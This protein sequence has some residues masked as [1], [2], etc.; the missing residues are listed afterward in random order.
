MTESKLQAAWARIE[1]L[2]GSGIC[3]P[4]IVIV[5]FK[6]TSITDDDLAVFAA[7]PIVQMLDL[8]GTAITDKA[9]THLEHMTA[10]ES[11]DIIGTNITESAIAE[12]KLRHP[13]VDVTA[14]ATP[15]EGRINPF[16]REP[17]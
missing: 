3:E 4:E 12:F 9:L 6:D 10:L 8:S 14:K 17:M 15:T 13:S 1:S 5:S 7:F 2:G 16:T 11:L